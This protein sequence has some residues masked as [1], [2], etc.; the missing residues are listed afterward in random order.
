MALLIN[1]YNC[2]REFCA[3]NGDFA[4]D[5]CNGVNEAKRKERERWNA[6]TQ[7]QKIEELLARV[8]SLEKREYNPLIG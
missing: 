6:L 2:G 4:C 7:D 1:C 3:S 8:Q 5:N